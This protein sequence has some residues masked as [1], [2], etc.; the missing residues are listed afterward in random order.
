MSDV[1]DA[2]IF[3]TLKKRIENIKSDSKGKLLNTLML[4]LTL[5]SK[6]FRKRAQEIALM[7]QEVDK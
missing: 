3:E 2:E 1:S 6:K 7:I 4:S 5:D